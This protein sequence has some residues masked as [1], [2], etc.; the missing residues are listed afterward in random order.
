M[1]RAEDVV[2]RPATCRSFGAR[3]FIGSQYYKHHAPN[4]A[5]SPRP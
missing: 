1:Y 2:D 5:E 4:G 3:H